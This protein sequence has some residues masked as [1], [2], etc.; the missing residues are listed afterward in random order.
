MNKGIHTESIF[1]TAIVEHLTANGWIEGNAFNF[2]KDLSL[3]KKA[4]LSFVQESQP[5]EWEKLKSYYR[6]DTE[7]KFI[8]R[9]F[10][11]L[12]LRGMLD[13]V[14]HGITDSG[15]KFKLAYFKPDSKLNPD[16]LKQYN[17]NRL[18][19][20][21][22]VCFS[23]KNNKSID[24]LLSL[25]GLPIATIELKNHF[26]GQ[27]VDEAMEQY[28]TSR[29]PKEL[30]FQF[31]K[32]ALVHFTVDPDEVYFTTKL[33]SSGTRFFPFNKGFNNGGGNPPVKDYTTY[34]A[35]YFWE[36]ILGV[37]SWLEI[38]GR[39]MHLQKDEYLVDGKRY[40]KETLLFPRY[41]QLDVVRKLTEHAKVQGSGKRYLIQHSAGSGKS[42]SI[43][44]LAYRLSSLYNEADRKV[45]DSILVITDRNVLDQQLQN[46]IYQFEHKTGVVQRIDADSRQ[47]ADA[48]HSGV[49]I[50]I[51]TLQKFP[52]AL[53][54]LA[55][56]S[57]RNYAVIIDEAHSSQGG[58]ASRKMTEALVGKNVSLE[59]SE[60]VEGEIE[61][62]VEDADDYIRETILKRGPQKNISL[63]AFTATPK[64]KTLEVFGVKD[65]EGKPKPF[66]LYS[67]RQAIEEGFIL[68]VLRNYTTY[69]TYYQFC[70]IIEED[71]E[72][73]K[74]KAAKAIGR[75]A[76]LHPTNLAQKTEVMVEHFRQITMKKIGGKAKAMVVTASRK[77]ALRYYL[78]FKDYIKEKGYTG[79]RPLVAFSG[80]VIDDLYPEGVTET[81]LNKF[82]EKELPEKFSTPEY[83]VLLV[84]DK[85][86]YGFDQPLLHTMYVDKKLSGVRAVQTLS[87]LNR[88]CPGKEDTFVLDF[89]NDRQTI[90]DSFQPY[91]EL[92]TMAETTDPNHLYDLKGI[93]DKAQVYYQSEVNA[94]SKVFYKP[95][96]VSVKDQAKLYAYIDPAVDRFKE[97]E[98][99]PQEEFKKSM[100]SFV[101]LYSFLSQIMPFQDIELEKLYSYGRFLL[102]KLP[103]ID[104]TERLKLDNEVALEYYRLQKIAE[105]DLV[106]QVQG[107]HSLDPTTEAGIS[108][109]KDEKDRLSNIIRL[110]NDKFGTDFTEADRLY[111]EQIEQALYENEELKVRAKNN[112]IEN[113]KYAFEEVFIQTL[114]DRMDANQDIF[115]KIMENSEFK[116]DVK[117]WLAKRIYQRFKES[118]E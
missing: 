87:R 65:T 74:R 4:V 101:R 113:F 83:Q 109:P 24:L 48:I 32:R 114:I 54:Y 69:E 64:A 34:R 66:H 17:Y 118:E 99:E 44:W 1:E 15:V 38:I 53:K 93:T 13:V 92:T 42:N 110:L 43:A 11:E 78:E 86:Q 79:I 12:D 41:H 46:T 89:A 63:F 28:R 7:S 77:H 73:N 35:A 57:K 2:S 60:K 19:V 61:K 55:E 16:T 70:K 5:V 76:S 95:G 84:A 68:D 21:R 96:N 26:T 33:E 39:F 94:F 103:K 51:T 59:E 117:D 20:T 72:L 107:E 105:G 31:K 45:F 98:E 58:E 75:F 88:T 47:L 104:Y 100:T 8:H 29:D 9:L 30:L 18:Y 67:M 108:K 56:I 27:R 85:Y 25:N 3:D 10:K 115:E 106:L 81:Q 111:F 97:L 14:R 90:I 116:Q 6:E 37:D 49:G 82:G 40:Y 71:P 22:Q 62:N 23:T 52:F 112:P 36:D 50:I 102:T 80:T 91:Y